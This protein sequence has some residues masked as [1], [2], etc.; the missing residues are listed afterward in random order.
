[1]DEAKLLHAPRYYVKSS[2]GTAYWQPSTLLKNPQYTELQPG[3]I[4]V[5]RRVNGTDVP[6]LIENQRSYREW[7]GC[8][9]AIC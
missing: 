7:L 9:S 5:M 1:M 6:L 2:G 4:Y 8:F 3:L